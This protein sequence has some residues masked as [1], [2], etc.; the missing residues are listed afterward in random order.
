MAHSRIY[1]SD[2]ESDDRQSHFHGCADI[3]KKHAGKLNEA[4]S[5]FKGNIKFEP[6]D[7]R[8]ILTS[9]TGINKHGIGKILNKITNDTVSI[10]NGNIINAEL[11]EAGAVIA[12][13]E[14]KIA[15]ERNDYGN[16]PVP[17]PLMELGENSQ[18]DVK[19]AYKEQLL[20]DAE[21]LSRKQ[22][23]LDEKKGN[24]IAMLNEYTKSMDTKEWLD[25]RDNINDL[26]DN[27]KAKSTT[28]IR[29]ED[30]PKIK[31]ADLIKLSRA[32]R[33]LVRNI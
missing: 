7:N 27:K 28:S 25:I 29:T 17:A 16:I 21:I 11:P 10:C 32:S 13:L 19:E 9:S 30:K 20:H 23:K 15:P 4:F 1:R 14:F 33:Q 8:L 3:L 26:I 5:M 24:L 6:K 18:N 22:E 12:V 31:I 2:D